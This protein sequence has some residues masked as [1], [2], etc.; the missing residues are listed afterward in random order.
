[1]NLLY[2]GNQAMFDG[3]M[4]SVLSAA[5]KSSRPLQVFVLTM[6]LR[7]LDSRFA[8]LSWEQAAYLDEMVKAQH[9][10]HSVRYLDGTAVFLDQM[11]KCPNLMS[12]Y[13]PYSLLRLVADQMD[14]PP[15]VLYVDCDTLFYGDIG[16]L[17]AFDFSDYPLVGAIDHLGKRFIAK[18]YVNTGVLHLNLQK[19]RDQNTFGR[20]R[21][22][23][24]EKAMPFPDQDALN[25]VMDKKCFLPTRFNEQ[26]RLQPDTIIQH[27]SKTIRFWPYFRIVNVKPWQIELVHSVLGLDNYDDLF[28]DYL[29]RRGKIDENLA[30]P[31]KIEAA[32]PF[33]RQL[34]DDLGEVF[35]YADQNG[36][37]FRKTKGEG[38]NP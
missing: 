23:C 2:C 37:I 18:D 4:L 27:F 25:E 7:A 1:M 24:M 30:P 9:P 19:I 15:Q 32:K 14:L 10:A 21:A 11:G 33:F 22:L 6:D 29:E 36:G 20:A 12:G 17:E 5:R 3:L 28:K 26:N 35:S 31:R 16:T 13:T 8:P 38:K 34:K